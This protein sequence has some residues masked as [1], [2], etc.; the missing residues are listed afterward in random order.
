MSHRG[1]AYFQAVLSV[2]FLAGYFYVLIRFLDGRVK[3]PGEF[4]DMIMTLLGVLTA[5]VGSVMGF[6]FARQRNSTDPLSKE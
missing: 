1:T 2:V 5:S 3:I 4:H 6:W